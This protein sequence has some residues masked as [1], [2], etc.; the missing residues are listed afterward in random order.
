MTLYQAKLEFRNPPKIPWS[1]MAL[2]AL[3][4]M[5]LVATCHVIF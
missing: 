4:L 2:E 3:V 1:H 5:S